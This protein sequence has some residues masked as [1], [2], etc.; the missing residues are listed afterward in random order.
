MAIFSSAWTI[1][2]KNNNTKIEK[3]KIQKYKK[4]NKYKNIKPWREMRRFPE[5]VIAQKGSKLHK[6][7]ISKP[8]KKKKEKNFKKEKRKEKRRAKPTGR[9]YYIEHH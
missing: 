3:N 2:E 9:W 8:K 5:D 7:T 6:K 1:Q 4:I